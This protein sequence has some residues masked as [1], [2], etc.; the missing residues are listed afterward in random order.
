MRAWDELVDRYVEEYSARGMAAKTIERLGHELDR[1]RAW[2][3][4]RRPR[5]APEDVGADLIVRYVRERTTFKSKETVSAVLS[6]LR[7]LGEFL[8]REKVWEANPLRWMR[9]PKLSGLRL[10]PRRLNGEAMGRLWEAAATCRQAYYRHL[11]LAVLL[12]RVGRVESRCGA[13]V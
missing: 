8:V 3:R 4:R 13:V 10:V 9:G 6:M 5:P 1:W 11:W 12:G 2:L 7:G